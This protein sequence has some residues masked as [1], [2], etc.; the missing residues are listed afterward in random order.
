MANDN[1]TARV[2]NRLEIGDPPSDI[3][4]EAH[5][6]CRINAFRRRDLAEVRQQ[7]RDDKKAK[8]A[9]EDALTEMRH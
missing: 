3:A 6:V 5:G 7:L 9:Q 1:D 8:A 2:K 4:S